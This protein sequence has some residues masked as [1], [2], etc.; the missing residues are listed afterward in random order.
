MAKTFN[1]RIAL[2]IRD[3]EPDWEPFLAP[4]APEGAPNVLIIVLGRPGLRDHGHLRWPGRL[5]EHAA[6]RGP[7][8]R[9]SRT[10]TRPRS[11]HPPGRHC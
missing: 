3:S 4:K 10:S 8:R 6:H 2:D 11:A 7:W 9:S 5:S 1:G